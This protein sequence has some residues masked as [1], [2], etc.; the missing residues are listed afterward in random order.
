[1]VSIAA[2]SLSRCAAVHNSRNIIVS[3]FPLYP[4]ERTAVVLSVLRRRL[5][6]RRHEQLQRLLSICTAGL[7]RKGVWKEQRNLHAPK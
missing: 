1:M 4:G 6:A 5:D 2:A 7:Q 3:R